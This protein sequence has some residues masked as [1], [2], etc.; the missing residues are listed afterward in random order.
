MTLAVTAPPAAEPVPL[1]RAK[2]HLRVTHDAEDALIADLIVAAR[3]RVEAS[4]GLCLLTTGLSQVWPGVERDGSVRL[5]RGPFPAV[6]AAF[7]GDGAG[8]WARLDPAGVRLEAGGACACVRLFGAG[9]GPVRIDYAAG[10][11][12]DPAD[13][14]AGLVQAVL[15][16]LADAYERRGDGDPPSAAVAEAWLAPFRAGR[17]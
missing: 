9:R 1:D 14:P 11:G 8:G 16:V 10:F 17:L 15:A 6:A 5:A 7:A 4:V 13:A 3:Q 2:A 12:P